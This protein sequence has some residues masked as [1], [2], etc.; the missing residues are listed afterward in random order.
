M[1]ATAALPSTAGL[2]PLAAIAARVGALLREG[3]HTVAVA[4]SSA[5]GLVSAALLAIPGASAFFIG[6]AV[7]YT[8]QSRRALLGLTETDM[9]GMRGSTVP[10]AVLIAGRVR[11]SHGATWGLGESGAAGPSGNRYGDAAGHVCLA[12]SGPLDATRT[13][14]TGTADRTVNMDVFARALLKLFEETLVSH[15]PSAAA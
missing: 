12:V 3:G 6:G 8:Q 7:V 13:I 1:S 2:P 9:A 11:E 15:P 10:Y 14:E 4:E 5:G